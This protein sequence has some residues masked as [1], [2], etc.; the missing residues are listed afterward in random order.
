M[1]QPAAQCNTGA[2]GEEIKPIRCARGEE[3][4]GIFFEGGEQGEDQACCKRNPLGG[5][6][7]KRGQGG[8]S[9]QEVENPKE[10]EM[11]HFVAV[12]NVVNEANEIWEF[13]CVGE[14][15]DE[16]NK[17]RKKGGE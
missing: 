7:V 8:A 4:L 17:S 1:R 6:V 5:A 12:G 15:N 9:G 2:T 13:I 10:D 3:T 16:D 11:S 14:N